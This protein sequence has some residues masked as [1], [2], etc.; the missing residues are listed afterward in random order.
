MIFSNQKQA[1]VWLAGTLTA[2]ARPSEAVMGAVAKWWGFGSFTTAEVD[3]LSLFRM[4]D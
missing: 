2:R 3:G 1:L 4:V